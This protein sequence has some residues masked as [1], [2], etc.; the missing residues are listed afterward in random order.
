LSRKKC[1]L[2]VLIY[3]WYTVR[4]SEKESV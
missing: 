1:I 3:L 4:E 2:T